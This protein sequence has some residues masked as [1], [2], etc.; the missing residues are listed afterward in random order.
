[1][2]NSRLPRPRFPLII[3]PMKCLLVVLLLISWSVVAR[4]VRFYLGT[5][6]DK[7]GSEGIYTGTL[8][9]TNGSLGPVELAAKAR[10]PSFVA[11][12][13]DR[14]FL[15]AL[16]S[17]LSGGTNGT[18]AAYRRGDDGSLTLLNELP[19]GSVCAHVSVDATGRCVFLPSYG[20][21]YVTAFRTKADGS[22]DR[23]TAFVPVTGRGPNPTRQTQPHPH[24]MYVDPEN[25]HV[26]A[27]DLGTDD[28]RTYNLDI[29]TGILTPANP[30]AARVAPGSGPRH[31]AFS[32]DGRFV[33]VNGEM[34][35]N[36]TVFER[37]P[38]TGALTPIQTVSTL[39]E[40]AP[41]NGVTTAE[42]VLHPSGKWLYVSNRGRGSIAVFAVGADGKLTWLQD[43]PVPVKIPRGFSLDPTGQWL[44]VGGQSD[45]KIAVLAVDGETGK[46]SPTDQTAK[47]GSV[48]CVVFE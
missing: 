20:A 37:H 10:N 15:Y 38:E 4:P 12:S 46:L 42:T 16:T 48:V 27:C 21:A 23:E 13:P 6:T 11:L 14:Q 5:Y 44:L 39:P 33:Y 43:A 3:R 22:L 31:L 19:T 26:Y 8:E 9:T 24:A 1:M 25:H 40:G 47:A 28:I 34:G 18:I 45:T 30:P 36:V 41:T 32:R 35:L 17:N 29:A 2:A 7:F